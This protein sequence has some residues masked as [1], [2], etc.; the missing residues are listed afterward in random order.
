[1]PRGRN[2]FFDI[3]RSALAVP[4]GRAQPK[5][6]GL[7]HN[8]NAAAFFTISYMIHQKTT[9][10]HIPLDNPLIQRV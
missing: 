1:L 2:K 8:N 3:C 5:K 9:M 10:E 7:L 4:A 6:P